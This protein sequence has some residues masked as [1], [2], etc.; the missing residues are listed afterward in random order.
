[1]KGLRT[2]LGTTA[3]LTLGLLAAACAGG[4][5]AKDEAGAGMDT[6]AAETMA[7]GEAPG[8]GHAM[9]TSVALA[10]RNESGIAGTAV[11]TPAAGDSLV[12]E[13][14]LSGLTAGQSYPAHVHHGTCSSPG[15]VAVG[16]ESV[17]ASAETG[18]S[19]TRLVDPRASDSAGPYL[20]MAHLPDGTPAACG[21]IPT[22]REPPATGSGDES[23]GGTGGADA[24]G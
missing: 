12:V 16:L 3:T 10:P 18:R 20:V 6:A 19:R 15:S 17:A 24:G 4:E 1:M 5:Q 21:E 22:E 14:S 8:G 9:G 23:G 11:L 2:T 7:G 13:L